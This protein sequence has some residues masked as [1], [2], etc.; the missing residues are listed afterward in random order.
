MTI[1]LDEDKDGKVLAIHVSGKLTKVDYAQLTPVF[2]RLVD[3][4]GKIRL[5]F[6]MSDFHGWKAGAAWEDF[7]LDVKHHAHIERI[8]MVGDKD[9]ER[10]MTT[11]CKP[12]TK[13]RVRYFDHAEGAAAR[14][15]LDEA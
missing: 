11:F 15:W 2:E 8:A 14:R 10:I 12:F 4:H 9:W 3:Q 7:K 5:L 6:D 1:Q 13:A